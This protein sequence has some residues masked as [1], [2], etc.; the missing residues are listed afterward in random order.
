MSDPKPDAEKL[1]G[2]AILAFHTVVARHYRRLSLVLQNQNDSSMDI[3]RL[4]VGAHHVALFLHDLGELR[5]DPSVEQ[6]LTV[7]LLD[8][9]KEALRD[10]QQSTSHRIFVD[11]SKQC[12]RKSP[13]SDNSPLKDT[14]AA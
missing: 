9:A 12:G 13:S 8:E 11:A 10:L 3:T 7:A 4:A 6:F 2:D 14:T 5:R 1:T